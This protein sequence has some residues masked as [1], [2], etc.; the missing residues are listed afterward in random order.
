MTRN[1]VM[2]QLILRIGILIV[3]VGAGT[4]YIISHIIKNEIE[5]YQIEEVGAA[6][7]ILTQTM[8]SS[9]ASSNTRG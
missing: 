3:V 8:K 5:E 2:T 7:K 1:T 4:I 9:K 6:A